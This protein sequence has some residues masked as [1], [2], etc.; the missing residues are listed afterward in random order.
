MFL[1][2]AHVVV[3]LCNALYSTVTFAFE[4]SIHTLILL[5]ESK[6]I[7]LSS[8]AIVSSFKFQ[9]TSSHTGQKEPVYLRASLAYDL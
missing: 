1:C 8:I 6:T 9:N 4:T 3:Q 7:R 5:S 2:L